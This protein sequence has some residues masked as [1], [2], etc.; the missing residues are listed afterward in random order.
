MVLKISFGV[1]EQDFTPLVLRLYIPKLSEACTVRV[2]LARSR[3]A[4]SAN[5]TSHGMRHRPHSVL[6]SKVEDTVY[7]TH[8]QRYPTSDSNRVTLASVCGCSSCW[9]GVDTSC[10][11]KCLTY[12]AQGIADKYYYLYI[13]HL[14]LTSHCVIISFRI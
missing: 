9:G 10:R 8:S 1:R 3:Y 14:A 5:L 13:A 12:R 11:P 4:T 2:I 7:K 6:N